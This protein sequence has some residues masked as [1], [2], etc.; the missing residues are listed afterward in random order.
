[1]INYDFYKNEFK[2]AYDEMLKKSIFK[3]I[4]LV[5]LHDI[6]NYMNIPKDLFEELIYNIYYDPKVDISLCLSDTHDKNK[7]FKLLDKYYEYIKIK[8]F[9]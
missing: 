3:R 1:M 2:K 4:G 5:H 9:E 6:Q 8:K 7:Q